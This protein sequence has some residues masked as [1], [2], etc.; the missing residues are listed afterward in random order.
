[1]FWVLFWRDKKVPRRKSARSA[2]GETAFDLS[3][4]PRRPVPTAN[5]APTQQ[6]KATTTWQNQKP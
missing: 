3:R 5:L 1:I 2:P 6:A 4:P